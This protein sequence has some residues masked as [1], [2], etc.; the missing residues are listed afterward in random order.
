MP[1]RSSLQFSSIVRAVNGAA[2]AH[3]LRPPT[4]RS[5]PKVPG[6]ART[7]R[8]WPSGS[9]TVAVEFKERPWAVVVA[10]CIEGTII[11]NDLVGAAAVR[12]RT[13]LWAHVGDDPRAHGTAA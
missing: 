9:V 3:G 7:I 6:A 2:R 8:R 11:A 5:P 10:D 1:A 4:F 12:A 13:A